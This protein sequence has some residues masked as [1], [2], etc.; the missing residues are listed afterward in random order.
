MPPFQQLSRIS[1][2]DLKLQM[3]K[4]V[5][6]ERAKQYFNHFKGYISLRFTKTEL[7][8]LVLLTI[9]KENI[10]LHNQIIKAILTNAI[11]S[12]TPP[13]PSLVQD[14]SKPVKGVRRKPLLQFAISN[15]TSRVTGTTPPWSN[16]I[17]CGE[18]P[19]KT[20]G[21]YL[22]QTVSKDKGKLLSAQNDG[23][24]R[25]VDMHRPSEHVLDAAEQSE[26]NLG[27]RP[28]HLHKRPRII[29]PSSPD[30]GLSKS[31]GDPL[32]S[33]GRAD[34]RSVEG[35]QREI[36]L[37]R[38]PLGAPFSSMNSVPKLPL[39]RLAG[40]SYLQLKDAEQDVCYSSDL[41]SA[42][43]VQRHMEHIAELEGLECVGEKCVELLNQGINTFL[44]GLIRS[45]IDPVKSRCLPQQGSQW[46]RLVSCCAS[47]WPS[48]AEPYNHSGVQKGLFQSRIS[49]LD[50]KSAMESNPQ[51]LGHLWPLQLE[52][53][54]LYSL[55]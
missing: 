14:T 4:R 34:S 32:S 53:L 18:S 21:P 17:I 41:P 19:K 27:N 8:K 44:E 35:C 13:S 47:N 3:V 5:G 52:R 23:T 26:A 16:G 15:D 46:E 29:I 2:Q 33:T 28:T 55:D 40:S 50:F 39:F 51:Q 1:V 6:P 20:T 49:F 30:M 54:Q 31:G 22:D 12:E 38:T 11:K 42:E 10:G 7:D 48:G 9:G 25:V 45:C 36:G 37:V 24:N 43:V